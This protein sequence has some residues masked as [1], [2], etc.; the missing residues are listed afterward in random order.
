MATEVT[1]IHATEAGGEL[2]RK[3]NEPRPGDVFRIEAL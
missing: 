3:T 2:E 1:F